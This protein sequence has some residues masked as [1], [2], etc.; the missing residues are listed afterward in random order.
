MQYL[1]ILKIHILF[2]VLIHYLFISRGHFQQ[3]SNQ[4]HTQKLS[5]QEEDL[6][7][8]RLFKKCKQASIRS[9]FLLLWKD[10]MA[11]S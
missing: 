9:E 7:K 2:I 8:Q 3:M 11:V 1:N 6:V 5:W 4:A 10:K